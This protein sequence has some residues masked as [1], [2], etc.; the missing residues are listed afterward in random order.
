MTWRRASRCV[1]VSVLALWSFQAPTQAGQLAQCEC[2]G[3]YRGIHTLSPNPVCGDMP[4]YINT[5]TFDA[6][7]CEFICASSHEQNAGAA[8]QFVCAGGDGSPM[9]SNATTWWGTWQWGGP[10]GPGGYHHDTLPFD[11]CP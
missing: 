11:N 9:P 8:C 1:L 5:Q 7:H 2:W 4:A 10:G 3:N 6:A